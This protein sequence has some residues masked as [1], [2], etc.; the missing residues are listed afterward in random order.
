MEVFNVRELA[1]Y[2]NCSI[3]SI[4]KLVRT[5]QIPNFRIGS[6]LNFKKDLIDKWVYSQSMNNCSDEIKK[7][8]VRI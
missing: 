7:E 4:R 2:L 8:E 3:S 6:K 5:N 1:T